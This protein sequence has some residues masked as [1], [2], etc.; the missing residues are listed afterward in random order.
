MRER[1]SN[2]SAARGVQPLPSDRGAAGSGGRR[3]AG[4]V[5]AGVFSAA[6]ACVPFEILI[7]LVLVLYQVHTAIR[8]W[9]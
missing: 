8:Q 5:R 7:Y 6:L 4:R 3:A 2:P 9:F 1:G